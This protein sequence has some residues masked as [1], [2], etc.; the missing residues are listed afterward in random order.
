MPSPLLT[1]VDVGW[2]GRIGTLVPALERSGYHR[3]W[4]TEHRNPGQS[5]SPAI[6]AA[7]AAAVSSRLRIGTAGVLLDFYSPLAVA[8]DFLLLETFF[9]GRIDLGVTGNTVHDPELRR[10]LLDGRPES[11]PDQIRYRK[12][13][14]EL[15]RLL[16][17]RPGA[18]PLAER[19]G[20]RP[21]R[22]PDLWICG[23]S[24]ASARLAGRLGASFC[25]SEYFRRNQTRVADGLAAVGGYREEFRPVAGLDRPR[26]SISC[27]GIC[28]ADA[29]RAARRGERFSAPQRASAEGSG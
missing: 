27:Y 10:L 24:E 7:L 21:A 4:A 13:I 20:P 8:E 9:P 1:V 2:P 15:A 17:G 18:S 5:A 11:D 25:F 12:K 22:P 19:I 14:E 28:G 26:W 16:P 29:A 6:L 3:Y 23:M